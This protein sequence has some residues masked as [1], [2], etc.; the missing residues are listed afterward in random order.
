MEFKKA[1]EE[2]GFL[3]IG[4]VEISLE[5]QGVTHLLGLD[6]GDSPGPLVLGDLQNFRTERNRL[7][8]SRLLELGLSLDWARIEEI[9]GGGQI[10]RPHFARHMIERGYCVSVQDAFDKYLGADGLAYVPKVKPKPKE[11]LAFLRKAG[12]AP[13][14]AHPISVKLKKAAWP[15]VLA[16]WKAG[17]LIGL[18]AYHP[19][20][21]PEDSLFY[22]EL[23]KR[24]D[25]IVTAGSDFHGANKKVPLNWTVLNAPVGLKAI[26]DLRKKLG[27]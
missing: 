23:A 10:G 9:S 6:L 20:Q 15:E 11:A 25:L 17:G 27:G 1:G 3:A 21:S 8:F 13:V 14:L 16:E 26:F 18:E 19:D 5:F 22:V 2:F 12:L 4:G 24:F 7:A